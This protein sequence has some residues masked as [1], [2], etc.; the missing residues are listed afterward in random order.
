MILAFELTWTGL[1]HAPGNSAT[2]QTVSLA[3]PGQ[4]IRVFADA[5]HVRE[6][7]SD[8]SLTEL[9][10]VSFHPVPSFTDY[11][12]QTHIVSPRRFL[13]EAKIMAR[14]VRG[15]DQREPCLILLLS[16]TP[17]AIFAASW[18]TKLLKR[19]NLG[20]QI[21][22]HGNAND[23]NGWRSRNPLLRRFDLVSALSARHPARVRFMVL[24]RAIRDELERQ[25][26]ALRSR[27]DILPLPVNANEFATASH[28]PLTEPIKIGFVGVATKAKGIDIYLRIAADLKRKYG[29]RIEF[30]HVGRVLPDTDL[31]PFRHLA[32]PTSAEQLPRD[33][34]VRRISELHYFAFPYREGYY[35]LSA[36]GALIDAI[37]WQRPLIAT[38]LP[39]VTQIFE[40]FGD[41]G[42]LCADEAA[43]RA[44]IDAVMTLDPSRYERQ[45]AA[46]ARAREARTPAHLAE[47]FRAIVSSNYPGLFEEPLPSRQPAPWPTSQPQN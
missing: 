30:H 46:L 6:L 33:E 28:P 45:S 37:T 15:V 38:A 13:Y 16:S 34:F 47:T 14:A 7:T 39:F 27:V 12:G 17:T 44:A 26:P 4:R 40:E 22:L 24:E 31:A 35:N 19:R 11:R 42:Y 5:P 25:V 2:L 41:I 1:T 10:N 32:H 23:I 36:S 3:F 21:G 8:T 9:S 29:A 20:I 43:L 18:L